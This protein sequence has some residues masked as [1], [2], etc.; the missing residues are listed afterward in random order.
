LGAPIV[1]VELTG[2]HLKDAIDDA[3]R[4]F[5]A[6]K[7]HIVLKEFTI[8]GGTN[9]YELPD[10]V[11]TVLEVMS[12]DS[13]YGIAVDPTFLGL[14]QDGAIPIACSFDGG[15]LPYSTY[16]MFLQN[17]QMG[18]RV[19]SAE[20]DWR[21]VDRQLH[22]FPTDT[23]ASIGSAPSGNYMMFYKDNSWTVEQLNERDHDLVK[24]YAKSKAKE[25][26]GRV[27]SKFEGGLP[28]AQE[29][30]TLDGQALLSESQTEI[31]DLETEISQSG[32]PMGIM[33]G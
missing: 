13:I 9:I 14:A 3:K 17:L 24:R 12:R 22:V 4:W 27:R 26:L 16:T 8:P 33:L 5:A 29:N 25:I 32:F 11:D 30:V 6:K 21:Q 2:D 18:K 10:N 28:G 23:E 20:F 7:G 1:R 19:Y 31:V 15:V